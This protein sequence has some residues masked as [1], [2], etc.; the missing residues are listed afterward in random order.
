MAHRESM[1]NSVAQYL[2]P[3]ELRPATG[4]RQPI[5]AGSET[6]RVHRCFFKDIETADTVS[7]AA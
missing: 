2:Q 5:P 4:V 7:A 3:D 1:R 6:L